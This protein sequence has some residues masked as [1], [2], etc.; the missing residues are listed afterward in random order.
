MVKLT[1]RA[2]RLLADIDAHG[3]GELDERA[4]CTRTGLSHGYFRA[5]GASSS[6]RAAWRCGASGGNRPTWC[7][8]TLTRRT[9]RRR[10]A[11]LREWIPLPRRFRGRSANGGGRS[12]IRRVCR[13]RRVPRM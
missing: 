5:R 11:R 10:L 1:E 13:A 9:G 7:C 12:V 8:S 2:K 4:I 3:G 6:R